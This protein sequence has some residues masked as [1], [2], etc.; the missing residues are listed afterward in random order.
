MRT[1][2]GTGQIQLLGNNSYEGNTTI[3]PD[4]RV[5]A[6]GGNGIPNGPGMGN[7]IMGAPTQIGTLGTYFGIINDETIN[8]LSGSGTIDNDSG[9][10]DVTL[11]IG[12]NDAPGDFSGTIINS[13][14]RLMSIIKIGSEILKLSG[15]NTYSGT[16][17]VLGGT[18]K[19]SSTNALQNSTLTTA[20]IV[21]DQAVGSNAF[22]LGGLSGSD[23]ITLE[24]DAAAAVAVS[25]G[26]NNNALATYSGVLS[27][28]GSLTKI[29]TGIQVLSGTNT[30]TGTTTISAGTLGF[31]QRSSFYNANGGDSAGYWT[32][33]SKW[34]V[35]SGAVAAFSVG[36]FG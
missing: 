14:S 6:G 9:T 15:D 36:G 34:S 7:L 2:G 20:G 26:N 21:F 27:G 28:A 30:Y 8:G 16:T 23:A 17:T 35:E 4:T 10:V 24:N 5:R 31:A 33:P 29:G 18:L 19:L 13:G 1:S 12:D 25:V 32:D 3:E 11:T 22:T